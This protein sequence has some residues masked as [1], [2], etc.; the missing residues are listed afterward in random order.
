MVFVIG[1]ADPNGLEMYLDGV[2]HWLC[3]I[4]TNGQLYVMSFNLTNMPNPCLLAYQFF[5][6]S[7]SRKE[8]VVLLGG[9]G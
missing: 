7:A 5:G 3:R 9:I 1:C 4:I 6:E 8:A 2:C